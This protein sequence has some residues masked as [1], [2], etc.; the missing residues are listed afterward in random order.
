MS[1]GSDRSILRDLRTLLPGTKPPRLGPSAPRGPL[2]SQS[3]EALPEERPALSPSGGG[4]GIAS[5]LTETDI[6]LRQFHDTAV[7]TSADG[8][9]TIEVQ[10]IKRIVMEDANSQEVVFE[11]ADPDPGDPE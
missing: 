4:D 1:S 6:A 11:Y 8:V 5:P 9:F 10:A 2:P 3:R 7:F